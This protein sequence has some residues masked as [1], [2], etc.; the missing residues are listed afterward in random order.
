MII[1]DHDY[2]D[3]NDKRLWMIMLMIDKPP[4]LPPS[5]TP[6]AGQSSPWENV[7][8]ALEAKKMGKTLDEF[9]ICVKVKIGPIESKTLDEFGI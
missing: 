1:N 8:V 6:P 9:G 2:H 3:E 5:P 7:K 4:S